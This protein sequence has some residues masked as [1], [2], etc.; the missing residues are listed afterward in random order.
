MSELAGS[1][2]RYICLFF[3]KLPGFFFQGQLDQVG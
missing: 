1:M 3:K 2:G